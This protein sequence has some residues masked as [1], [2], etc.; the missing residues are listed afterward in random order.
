MVPVVP[1]VVTTMV[2]VAF[3]KYLEKYVIQR[4]MRA[5]QHRKK[6]NGSGYLVLFR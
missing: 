2:M 1:V 4:W 3:E 5:R 6:N